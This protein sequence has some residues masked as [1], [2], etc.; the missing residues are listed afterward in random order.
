MEILN[1]WA[2]NTALMMKSSASDRS[3]VRPRRQR[4]L[5][6]GEHLVIR[7]LH[8]RAD[9]LGLASP[10]DSMSPRKSRVWTR[11][12]D[13]RLLIILGINRSRMT[14]LDFSS[15]TPSSL[16]KHLSKPTRQDNC[17]TEET[18]PFVA[19][20]PRTYSCNFLPDLTSVVVC[21]QFLSFLE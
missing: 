13:D 15:C 18:Y 21:T 12:L 7:G 5:L 1:A 2:G 3:A 19:P 11:Q 14:G 8:R 9:S 4:D 20:V 6:Y 10:G 17:W 16:R